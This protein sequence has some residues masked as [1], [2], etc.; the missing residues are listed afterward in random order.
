MY[1]TLTG[2]ALGAGL[3][4]AGLA[5]SSHA[6]EVTLARL[7]CGTPQ[8]PTVANE[9]FSDT[10]AFPGLSVQFVF[11]CYVVKHGDDYML[12]DTGHSMTAPNVAPKVSVVDQ[13]ARIDVKPDQI[14]YVGISHYHAD[15]TGQ[16]ASFPKATLLIGAREWEAISSPNPAQGVNA[17]PFEGWIKGENKVEP[18]PIDKDVFGD[19]S[20]IVLRTPGHTP[21]HSSLLVKLAQ[22]GPVVLTGDA[23]HFHENYDT[24]GVPAFNFDRAQTVASIERLKKIAASLKGTVIIQH[25]ARDVEKLPVFPT[26]AK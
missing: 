18:Q 8:Q 6:A 12:W 1:R 9:R 25:D 24:D 5:T 3:F 26:F 15:H 7:D 17:K 2:F 20:V 16:I 10:Y 23:V 14:K 11:S 4:I 19:G 21:G 22:M 13:L